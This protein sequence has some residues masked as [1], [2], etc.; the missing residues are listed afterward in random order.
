M[1]RKIT[2]TKRYSQKNQWLKQNAKVDTDT[3]AD[4]VTKKIPVGSVSLIKRRVL[5]LLMKIQFKLFFEFFS[6]K[7][8]F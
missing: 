7:P 5:L 2:L 6:T 1:K 3:D 8:S 4:R